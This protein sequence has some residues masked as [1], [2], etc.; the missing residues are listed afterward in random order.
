MNLSS[1]DLSELQPKLKKVRARRARSPSST[2][3]AT[4]ATD[5]KKVVSAVNDFKSATS[6]KCS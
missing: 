1:G 6:S 3:L 5:V 2:Q 4:I